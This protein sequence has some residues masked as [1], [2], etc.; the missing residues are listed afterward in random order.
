M[1]NLLL[2]DLDEDAAQQERA[3]W[4]RFFDDVRE[5][6]TSGKVQT[7]DVGQLEDLANEF[8]ELLGQ[9]LLRRLAPE[10][11]RGGRLDEVIGQTYQRI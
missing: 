10:Y 4:Y 3:R 1:G 9:D 2:N 8:L 6:V 7:S 11:E 5:P